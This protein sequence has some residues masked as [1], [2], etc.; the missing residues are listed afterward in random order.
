MLSCHPKQAILSYEVVL[1][2]GIRFASNF[3]KMLCRMHKNID[4]YR[5]TCPRNQPMWKYSYALVSVW[6]FARIITCH[7]RKTLLLST[8]TATLNHMHV[9]R[10]LA[11]MK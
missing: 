11:I 8:G 3:V 9:T 2:P 6:K 7:K 4:R 10:W 5:I 1:Q